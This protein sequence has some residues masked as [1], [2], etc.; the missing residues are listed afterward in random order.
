MKAILIYF[1]DNC[2]IELERRAKMWQ[3]N[4]CNALC[5]RRRLEF[6]PISDSP[7][8]RDKSEA[9]PLHLWTL[10]TFI[11]SSPSLEG[12]WGDPIQS[13]LIPWRARRCLSP[14]SFSHLKW[15][16]QRSRIGARNL[17]IL[18]PE[19]HVLL[20]LRLMMPVFAVITALTSSTSLPYWNFLRSDPVSHPPPQFTSPHL[21][22]IA[23]FL[24]VFSAFIRLLAEA[25]IARKREGPPWEGQAL[26]RSS[27]HVT[28]PARI[29]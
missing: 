20:P 7:I 24:H 29:C 23:C 13:L 2:F 4:S 25:G 26:D 11:G 6:D 18:S 19:G 3:S 8:R 27:V 22:A 1:I 16:P 12:E 15:K 28:F 10:K 5:F 21:I 17:M 9:R 14:K